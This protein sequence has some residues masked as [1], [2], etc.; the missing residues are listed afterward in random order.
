MEVY[1]DYSDVLPNFYTTIQEYGYRTESAQ[2]ASMDNN[3]NNDGDG[4][5]KYQ[6]DQ[7]FALDTEDDGGSMNLGDNSKGNDATTDD[8][9]KA[10]REAL[11]A[12]S[13]IINPYIAAYH[14]YDVTD[15][16]GEVTG[17]QLGFD[18]SFENTGYDKRPGI[19]PY[20][21]YSTASDLFITMDNFNVIYEAGGEMVPLGTEG[22]VVTSA[23][24][25]G[26]KDNVNSDGIII[27]SLE[28]DNGTGENIH[29]NDFMDQITAPL[30]YSNY[31]NTNSSASSVMG[32]DQ[33]NN[34]FVS[35]SDV[36]NI[37]P[38]TSTSFENQG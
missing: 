23:P 38:T 8:V 27:T 21:D 2:L 25:V 5:L 15:D 16:A 7:L 18:L 17:N 33:I 14:A 30:Y 1:I 9:N 28:A 31:S 32:V 3:S 12:P 34:G 20:T 6:T 4:E 36:T 10:A 37:P 26:L 19:L 13:E 24:L 11:G 29:I 22:A 35:M